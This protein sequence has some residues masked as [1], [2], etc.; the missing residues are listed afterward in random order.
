MRRVV[1]SSFFQPGLFLLRTVRER[2]RKSRRKPPTSFEKEM[3]LSESTEW[4]KNITDKMPRDSSTKRER[5]RLQVAPFFLENHLG[6]KE[7]FYDWPVWIFARPF[8]SSFKG[9]GMELSRT[10]IS[11]HLQR[12]WPRQPTGERRNRGEED[13]NSFR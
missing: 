4:R 9:L 3:G 2:R 13:K 1:F 7:I 8:R 5:Q 10:D 6:R 12:E 11:S